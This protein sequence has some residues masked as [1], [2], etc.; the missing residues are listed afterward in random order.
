M[1]LIFSFYKL[2]GCFYYVDFI[3]SCLQCETNICCLKL[4]RPKII[5]QLINTK[6][7]PKLKKE[8]ITD[9]RDI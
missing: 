8:N 3:P 9:Y 7:L 1:G 2:K 6:T 5:K 4:Q